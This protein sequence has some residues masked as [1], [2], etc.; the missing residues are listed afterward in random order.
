MSVSRC[1]QEGL[2][3]GEDFAVDASLIKAGPTTQAAFANSRDGRISLPFGRLE[4]S[5]L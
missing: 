4:I 2:V 1:I 3:G 5:Q